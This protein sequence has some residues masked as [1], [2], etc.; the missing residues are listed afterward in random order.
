V[1]AAFKKWELRLKKMG[2]GSTG[3]DFI[4]EVCLPN[5]R[6]GVVT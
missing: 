2:V 1:G 3:V 4:V 5:V 6:V